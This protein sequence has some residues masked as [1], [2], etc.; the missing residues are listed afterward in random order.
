VNENEF[1][2]MDLEEFETALERVHIRVGKVSCE[3]TDA[4]VEHDKLPSITFVIRLSRDGERYDSLVCRAFSSKNKLG[5]P[6]IHVQCSSKANQKDILVPT[7][8]R[9]EIAMAPVLVSAVLRWY[10]DLSFQSALA[11]TRMDVEP[12]EGSED[13]VDRLR[14]WFKGQESDPEATTKLHVSLPAGTT[15]VPANTR[16]FA[17]PDRAQAYGLIEHGPAA[18][19]RIVLV[20]ISELAPDVEMLEHFKAVSPDNAGIEI[21]VPESVCYTGCVLVTRDV[22][23]DGVAHAASEPNQR[24]IGDDYIKL[25]RQFM[26]ANPTPVKFGADQFHVTSQAPHGTKPEY[27]HQHTL[28]IATPDMDYYANLH[29]YRDSAITEN[30]VVHASSSPAAGR[31]LI[32]RVRTSVNAAHLLKQ[33]LSKVRDLESERAKHATAAAEPRAQGQDPKREFRSITQFG[34]TAKS[35][36]GTLTVKSPKVPTYQDYADLD[37]FVNGKYRNDVKLRLE[38]PHKG[39]VLHVQGTFGDAKIQLDIECTRKSFSFTGGDGLSV[40][41]VL[42]NKLAH[43]MPRYAE[44]NS[45]AMQEVKAEKPAMEPIDGSDYTFYNGDGHYPAYDLQILSGADSR[46]YYLRKI[47]LTYVIRAGLPY[48]SRSEKW[49]KEPE[50]KVP[51]V[52][53]TPEQ[54]KTRIVQAINR[55][56]KPKIKAIEAEKAE[57]ERL[58]RIAWENNDD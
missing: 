3:V 7:R 29:G 30:V 56:L 24:T 21:G 53:E 34:D 52:P 12:G 54:F 27:E 35:D 42:A 19:L 10:A 22:D 13:K 38:I 5:N 46:S 39:N 8:G 47:N 32:G 37:V 40:L 41:K 49:Y 44:K 4:V 11:A 20:K 15:T 28:T 55:D 1:A 36:D 31:V 33:I 9:T 2:G 48:F 43:A 25:V 17:H 14:A 57:R 23:V 58:A 16:A 26:K 50:L 51:V 18:V 45:D 6:A